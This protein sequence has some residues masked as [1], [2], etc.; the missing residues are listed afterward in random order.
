MGRFAK[1]TNFIRRAAGVSDVRCN[2]GGGATV[3]AYHAQPAG[4]DCHP[5]PTDTAVLVETPRSNNYA[6]VGV[7]DP[8]NRQTAGP[9]ERRVYS[10][11][12][13]GE[14][15]AEVFLHDDGQVRVSND[16]GFVDLA[17][18]GTIQASNGQ[19]SATLQGTSITL[20]DGA[21]GSISINGGVITLT[22]T[23]IR[24]IGPVDANGA[25]ISEA[26]Q[27]TDADGLSVH[28]HNHTQAND[29]DND[30]QQPTSTAQIPAP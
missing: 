27:I 11:N 25:T 12:A 4:D 19:A 1:I 23:A 10:R 5:L 20:D 14:Q 26:G 16:E 3:D 7:V 17:A 24:L 29:S 2:P 28:G 18:D 30:V 6:A 21:G 9:G 22:G 13:D 15:V 8:N